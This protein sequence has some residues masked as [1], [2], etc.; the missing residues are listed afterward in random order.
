MNT[1]TEPVLSVFICVHLW[2]PFS[3]IPTKCPTNRG[4]QCRLIITIAFARHRSGMPAFAFSEIIERQRR[5]DTKPRV[6]AQRLP[7]DRNYDVIVNPNGV[8]SADRS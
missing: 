2:L 5:S 8:A 4:R 1:D 7:W 6:G 3:K